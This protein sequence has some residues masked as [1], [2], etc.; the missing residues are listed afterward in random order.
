[1]S[2]FTRTLVYYSEQDHDGTVTGSSLV[3]QSKET[4]LSLYI[5]GAAVAVTEEENVL[6]PCTI[7]IGTN[8]PDYNNIVS[9]QVIGGI[10]GCLPLPVVSNNTQIPGQ[11]D[12]Y[13]KVNVA[14]IPE[15]LQTPTLNFKVMIE[16]IE[17]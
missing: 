1:M 4:E 17:L 8:S 11:T 15:L 5:I 10:V 6:T 16:G 9:A 7:S 14:C 3:T 12:I 2:N 13:V